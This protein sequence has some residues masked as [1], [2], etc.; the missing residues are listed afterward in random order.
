MPGMKQQAKERIMLFLLR[1]SRFFD[2]KWYREQAGIPAGTD[3]AAHYLRGGWRTQDPSPGFRQAEYLAANEDVRRADVCPL[4]H[5]L[6]YGKRQHYPLYPGYVEN[7]YHTYRVPRMLLRVFFETVFLRKR[8]RNRNVRLLVIAHVWYPEALGE[9]LEYC[10]NLRS[11]PWDLVVTTAEG[12]N[13]E[14]VRREVLRFKQDAEIREYPNRGLDEL[15]FLAELNRKNTEGYDLIVK[16]H[17]K[18]CDPRSGRLAEGMYF[19]KRDWFLCLF[20]AVLGAGQVHRNIDRLMRS[21]D[22]DLIAARNLIRHDT[23]RKEKLANRFLAQMGGSLGTR[24]TWVAGGVMMM[25]ASCAA[26]VKRLSLQ[27]EMFG[28]PIPGA[29]CAASALERYISGLIPADRKHGNPVCRIRLMINRIRFGGDLY[30]ARG[31]EAPDTA[32]GEAA[33]DGKAAPRMLTAAFAV[34]ETGENAV[35]GDYFTALELAKA[36]EAR[37]W[38]TK[39]LSRKDPGNRWYRVGPETDVLISMLEDYDPQ[40]IHDDNPRLVTVG[41]ARNWFD[42]WVKS[43]GTVLYD[44][45]MASSG[46]AC[47]EMA[48]CLGREVALLPIAANADRFRITEEK[49]VNPEYICDICFTGNRFGKRGIENQLVPETLPGTLHIYGE[50]WEKVKAF[51]PYLKGHLP[52]T[53]IPEAYRGAKIVLDDAT[54]STQRTGAVNSRVYD[55]LAAGC[56]VLTNNARGAEETFQG[57]LPVFRNREELT[58]L[59]RKYLEDGEARKEKVKV[60]RAFVLEN[61]TYERRAAQ[62]EE[63]LRKRTAAAAETA[64]DRI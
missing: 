37:G 30:P 50:G 10:R 53:E 42:R 43:P 64:E 44:V 56:L 4:A 16:I 61:H 2:A 60:L 41:W 26:P 38:G 13:A 12:D 15:P 5:W 47:R 25:R 59:V 31:P 8:K 33:K 6:F 9:M 34:T 29:F 48:E 63:I 55:A 18:R 51:A 20:R 39:F 3:A 27:P 22:T 24:Y 57:L 32:A 28:P 1:H 17:S 19:R 62:L 54:P 23:P 46:T 21:R 49:P 40:H 45:L 7:H 14:T 11:Y 58:E 52:Y 35:A 36:L